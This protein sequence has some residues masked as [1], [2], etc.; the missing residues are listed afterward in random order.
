MTLENEIKY[1]RKVLSN[2]LS[3]VR[4]LKRSPPDRYTE[5]RL[6]NMQSWIK[7]IDGELGKLRGRFKKNKK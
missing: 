7:K 3:K 6:E 1:L 5:G 4:K 2:V